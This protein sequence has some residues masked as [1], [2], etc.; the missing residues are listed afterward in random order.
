GQ[1]KTEPNIQGIKISSDVTDDLSVGVNLVGKIEGQAAEPISEAASDSNSALS[2]EVA[3]DLTPNLSILSEYA[4]SIPHGGD[5][6]NVTQDSD[7][8]HVE[9]SF[10]SEKIYL[11][12]SYK[13]V[14]GNFLLPGNDTLKRDYLEYGVFMDYYPSPYLTTGFYYYAHINHPSDE[15]NKLLN[16]TKSVDISLFRP[17]L[18]LVTLTYDIHELK[19]V[20]GGSVGFPVDDVT[21]S[22]YGAFFQHFKNIRF[23]LGYFSSHYQDRTESGLE[24]DFSLMTYRISTKLWDRLSISATQRM[25]Q[26]QT[27]E[28]EEERS[29]ILS[30][31]MTYAIIPQKLTF[32]PSWKIDRK[33]EGEDDQTTTRAILRYMLS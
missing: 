24:D 26:Q 23:S 15:A 9:G 4:W 18:P 21:Y 5:S 33:G 22:F 1:Q 32:S 25:E 12:G 29:P 16:T 14:G 3:Y 30:L 8:F 7:A 20:S 13:K 17:G 28:D 31:A 11:D 2:V 10:D 19:G 27:D 6:A